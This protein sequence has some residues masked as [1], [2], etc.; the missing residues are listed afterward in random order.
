MNDLIYEKVQFYSLR[1][2]IFQYVVL[3]KKG[4][5]KRGDDE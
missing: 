4:L 5:L 3:A 1:L 2:F